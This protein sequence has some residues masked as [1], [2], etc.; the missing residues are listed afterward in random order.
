[1]APALH[2]PKHAIAVLRQTVRTHLRSIIPIGVAVAVGVLVVA[3]LVALYA[4]T[5]SVFFFDQLAQLATTAESLTTLST[6]LMTPIALLAVLATL[7][8]AGVAVQLSY[9]AISARRVS[10]GRSA[11]N[12]LRRAPRAFV[13]VLV[14]TVCFTGAVLIAPVLLVVGVLGLVLIAVASRSGNEALARLGERLPN[15]S[16][17]IAMAVP[18]GVAVLLLGRWSLGPASVWLADSGI[19]ASL[20][21]S[22]ERVRS[23]T[24]VV[25]ATLLLAALVTLGA[26]EGFVALIALGGWGIYPEFVARVVAIIVVGPLLFVASAVHYRRGGVENG[27]DAPPAA[28]SVRPRV[29][30]LARTAVIVVVALLV[31]L[32]VSGSPAPASAAT[33][34]GESESE[35]FI[36]ASPSSP[37]P[38]DVATDIYFTVTDPY[39]AEGVQPTGEIT[40]TINGDV[41]TGPFELT[42]SGYGSEYVLNRTFTAGSHTIASTYTG[43][44]NYAPASHSIT[45]TA[46]YSSAIALASTQSPAVYG[47]ATSL[48]ATL[49]TTG[50]APT[51]DVQFSARFNGGSWKLIGTEAVSSGMAVLD[52]SS[53]APGSYELGARY[54]GD[55]THL[56]EWQAGFDHSVTGASTT[57]TFTVSPATPSAAG[58]TLTAQVTVIAP[59]SAAAPT[60][61]VNIYLNGGGSSLGNATLSGGT[62]DATFSLPPGSNQTVTAIYTP[63]TGFFAS[64]SELSHTVSPYVGGVSVFASDAATV[65]GQSLELTATVSAGGTATGSVSFEATPTTGVPIAL[66]SATLDGSGKAALDT[67]ALPVGDYAI[68]ASYT[69]D[70]TVG[71]GASSPLAHTVAQAT[72]FVDVV[73]NVASTEFGFDPTLTIT[74]TAVAPGAGTPS[75]SVT[76]SRDGTELELVSVNG[77]GVATLV[78]DAGDTGDHTFSAAYSGDSSFVAATGTVD[79]TV[80]QLQTAIYLPSYR[81]DYVYG[82]DQTFTGGVI[83]EPRTDP[84]GSVPTGTVQLWIHDRI[85]ATGALDSAGGYSITT[86][87]GTVGVAGHLE[88]WVVYLGDNNYAPSDSRAWSEASTSVIAQ[89]NVRPVMS[90]DPAADTLGVGSVVT[91]FATMP[92]LGAGAT[93]DV[94]FYRNGDKIGAGRISDDVASLEYTLADTNSTIT[95]QYLGDKNFAA[96]TSDP[97]YIIVGRNAVV[98]E[99]ADP[100][101]LEYSAVVDL[102]ATVTIGAGVDPDYG[103]TFRTTSNRVLASNVPIDAAGK[104]TLTVCAGDA[105]GCPDG[106]ILLGTGADGIYVTYLETATNLPGLSP[107]V[108]YVLE[109][110]AT[111]TTVTVSS[112]TVAP[113]DIVLLTA[114]VEGVASPATPTNYVAFYGS[115]PLDGG[116]AALAFI[117][118]ATLIGG[119]ATLIVGVGAGSTELRWPADSIVAEYFGGGTQFASSSGSTPIAIDRKPV[120]FGLPFVD[121]VAYGSTPVTVYLLHA[122]GAIG[123]YTGKVVITAASGSSCAQWVAI[124]ER[125][126][127]CDI[128]FSGAGNDSYTVSYSGDIVSAPST[129]PETIVGVDKATPVLGATSPPLPIVGMDTTV[130]WSQFHP[131][132]TGTVTV[133]GNAA[134]WCEAVPL[135][136]ESCTGQF[137]YTAATGSP[138]GITVQYSG[139]SD[140]NFAEQFLTVTVGRCADL[141]VR[142]SDTRMGTVTVDTAPNCGA[143]G[144]LTG[145]EV[146][147]SAEP[148]APNEF[149]RWRWYGPTG[150]K[151]IN[152]S[153]AATTSFTVT[154][155]SFT[156]VHIADFELPCY[157]VMANATGS[158]TI[159]VYPASN[160]TTDAGVAGYL[161]GTAVRIY[162]SPQFNRAY[163]EE[164]VFYSFGTQAAGATIVVDSAVTSHVAT[165]V[166]GTTTIPVTFGPRCRTVSVVLDP[167]TDG[168]SSSVAKGENCQSPLGNGYVRGSAVTVS[169]VPGDANYVL[170]GWVINGVDQPELGTDSAPTLRIGAMNVTATAK[171]L[172]CYSFEALVSGASNESGRIVGG[173]NSDGIA[174]CPDGSDRYTAGTVIT[175]TPEVRVEG[176]SFSGW[177][178]KKLLT[179]LVP[180]EESGVGLVTDAERTVTITSDLTVTANFFLD[181]ACSRLSVIGQTSLMT[182]DSTGCGVGYY[183]DRQKV[184]AIRSGVEASE[185]WKFGSRTTLQVTIPDDEPLSVYASVRGDVRGCFGTSDQSTGPSTDL[186]WKTY[187]PLAPGFN[188]CGVGGAIDVRLEACQSVGAYPELHVVGDER[189]FT[190]ASLPRSMYVV[191]PDGTVGSLS[192]R[193]FGWMQSMNVTV[194]TDSIS[195]SNMR[196]GPCQDAG[197]AFPAGSD[198]AIYALSPTSGFRFDGWAN[199]FPNTL[200]EAIEA[201]DLDIVLPDLLPANPMLRTTN[202]TDRSMIVTAAYTVTCHHLALGEGIT[203]VGLIPRCPGT[204]PAE[205]MY[206]EGSVVQTRAAYQVGGRQNYG[207]TDGVISNQVTKDAR[208]LDL[209]GFVLMTGNR[210]VAADY[211]NS[212][213]KFERGVIQG[214]KISAGIMAVAAPI[215][216]GLM[217]PPMGLFFAVV[218]AGAGIASIA[219]D[220]KTASVFDMMNPTSMTTCAAR[221]AFDN[222]GQSTGAYNAGAIA[223]VT[224]TG[225]DIVQGK[226]IVMKPIADLRSLP[227]GVGAKLPDKLANFP[228]GLSFALA[229]AGFGYGLYTAGIGDVP[230]GVQTVEQLRGTATM[231]GCV[232]EKLRFAGAN[233]SGN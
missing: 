97:F 7:V 73:S 72:A 3:A 76:V 81:G 95:A 28:P 221:W 172:G 126:V 58:D 226:D 35:V 138:V 53:L 196:G 19:R 184:N 191:G 24:A 110:A 120:T 55:S 38:A 11:L 180:E 89:A 219:G 192:L 26:T 71:A 182:F 185:I 64:R 157:T 161:H 215:A 119:V 139:D 93:G 135:S 68:V 22:S 144:Y 177:D 84:D 32:V 200:I 186:G 82:D 48:T 145:T 130:N 50:A 70:S 134:L 229:A 33:G 183:F 123:N 30:R 233:T 162:P 79:V 52:I 118:N 204:E 63:G 96:S 37:F 189:V 15:R 155:D 208:T 74:V 117:G 224:K 160:C 115:N 56:A 170:A 49:T 228:G 153:V 197:N 165:T 102:V 174:N 9:A 113:G 169:A 13:V 36:S 14:I 187:G 148:V 225:Y 179:R 121:A 211:P 27:V 146:T 59:N 105:A 90:S 29:S 77:S 51:G 227:L 218:A 94:D 131:G 198:V 129:S 152:G 25:G 62:G 41:Q 163:N 193:D 67:T 223:K 168:D 232:D 5:I 12:A 209:L 39:T 202:D 111:T 230:T 2:Q 47:S 85:S 45:V 21:D 222:S 1:M 122:A 98:I 124:G 80:R 109:S 143:T 8:W 83:G 220:D 158:G 213:E 203:V 133:W 154:T 99:L 206:I 128:S 18:F 150:S 103:V 75:G 195:Y 210:S 147:V 171:F 43:D 151:L 20:R 194:N 57:T 44:D 216:I 176:T 60:G 17:L 4:Q 207:Y 6:I 101:P 54:L 88:A 92:H 86:D 205:N 66:G 69:G 114:T 46:G 142:S 201:E 34:A 16:T 149:L 31:P 65:F 116:G 141:D 106:A 178:E 108:D 164:D 214:L 125:S 78:V 100:G 167:A 107:T 159:G 199:V 156:W 188:E 87:L 166:T 127:T 61:S 40:I 212:T 91:F 231:A 173:V 104:A 136:D 217:F 112:A 23:H 181:S 140:W 42:P 10:T 132:A 175:L 190:D 137:D